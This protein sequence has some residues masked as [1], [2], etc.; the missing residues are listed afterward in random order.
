MMSLIK[1]SLF[2]RLIYLSPS[3]MN[4]LHCLSVEIVI[5]ITQNNHE[6]I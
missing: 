5:L 6:N 1:L 3:L 4:L 2:N